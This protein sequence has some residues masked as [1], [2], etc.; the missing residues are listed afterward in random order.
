M[1]PACALSGAA[2]RCRGRMDV[3]V[4]FQDARRYYNT[5]VCGPQPS[6]A[7]QQAIY[8]FTSCQNTSR[9]STRLS[10]R[11][12][13]RP[14][15]GIRETCSLLAQRYSFCAGEKRKCPSPQKQNQ[16]A[17]QPALQMRKERAAARKW[18]C[19]PREGKKSLTSARTG[20][21]K[22]KM[23]NLPHSFGLCAIRLRGR[24]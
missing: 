14:A 22:P 3:L 2:E 1:L 15:L 19:R 4:R 12:A 13:Y 23:L 9:S 17:Q 24:V 20:L 8:L 16:A 7:K 18:D 21:H 10:L 6:L 11:S 5:W